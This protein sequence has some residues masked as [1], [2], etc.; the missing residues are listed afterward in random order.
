MKLV[1]IHG[2][3]FDRHFWDPILPYFDGHDCHV[4]DLGFF[5]QPQH[6][7]S[8]HNAI[9]VGHS[10]GFVEGITQHAGWAA[11]VAINSFAHFLPTATNPG[12]VS[13]AALRVLRSKLENNPSAAM[14]S[15]YA[16]IDA[17]ARPNGTPD[18]SQLRHGLDLLR[19]GNT[20]NLM[21][22]VPSLVLSGA[23]DQLVPAEASNTLARHSNRHERHAEGGH[24]L[25]LTHA[26]WC[27]GHI[28]AFVRHSVQEAA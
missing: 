17:A 18:I 1:F 22:D 24:C 8:A 6:F 14:E 4:A 10:L 5:G 19:D 11:W 13:P 9:L 16:M 27:A 21:N 15:F 20:S 28:K 25:P 23:Q 3:A 2:W 7:G 26:E 12:C